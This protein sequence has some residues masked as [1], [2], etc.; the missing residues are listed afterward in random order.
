MPAPPPV[1]S[2]SHLVYP[3]ILLTA[4]STSSSTSCGLLLT[5]STSPA[6]QVLPVG[7]SV[8]GSGQCA[9]ARYLE[10]SKVPVQSVSTLCVR[11][12]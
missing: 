10:S 7:R 12:A 8:G 4:S 1:L 5:G 3:L 9:K 6:C 11:R 2:F